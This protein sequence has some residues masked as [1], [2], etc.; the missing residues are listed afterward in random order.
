MRQRIIEGG[1]CN[2]RDSVCAIWVT[3]KHS[4]RPVGSV[5]A[6]DN[7]TW[8]PDGCIASSYTH[9]ST[10]WHG[11][12]WTYLMRMGLVLFLFA[13]VGWEGT[14]MLDRP[15]LWGLKAILAINHRKIK[16][17]AKRELSECRLFLS[18]KTLSCCFLLR[19]M[20][21]K[22]AN[23]LAGQLSRK[24]V[25]S[26]SVY[27]GK[28]H[29]QANLLSSNRISQYWGPRG[30]LFHLRPGGYKHDFHKFSKT[31]KTEWMLKRTRSCRL[32]Q[33]LDFLIFCI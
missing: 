7:Y 5:T 30:S 15:R 13:V 23:R 29:G 10:S 32:G 9:S 18:R 26:L 17:Q 24:A 2:H 3:D 12:A 28:E 11:G 21:E 16:R 1:G 31:G 33:F 8:K 27:A 14:G 19:Q 20:K 4:S 22:T 25:S 6:E